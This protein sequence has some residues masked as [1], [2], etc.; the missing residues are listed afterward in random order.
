MPIGRGEAPANARQ[1]LRRCTLWLG[2]RIVYRHHVTRVGTPGL[3]KFIAKRARRFAHRLLPKPR[4]TICGGTR[5]VRGPNRR[6]SE[7][8]QKPCCKACRSLERHRAF[9][10]ILLRL[11]P[12]QFAA[13]RCLQFSKDPTADPA[14]FKSH[15]ISIFG[16]KN[17]LDL[18]RIAR[19]DASYDVIICNHVLE[20]V[21]DYRAALKELR[22][23]L[24]P[25]GFLLLSFPDPHRV[26]RTKD[27]GYADA[28][29]HGHYRI[30]GRD[31]E[32][33]LEVAMTDCR[34][35]RVVE[36][37]DVTG[38]ADMAYVIS[39]NPA[40]HARLGTR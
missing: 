1:L 30:F 25:R 7:S 8:G 28:S 10:K 9:R 29:Q 12:A 38:L 17:S 16:K 3:Q 37:D 22:R 40:L 13:W 32:A 23:V 36:R 2:W 19:A 31:V 15:E 4:C 35:A 33:E 11:D 39:A 5:F 27:W 14:W 18:Q 34:I 24:D 6:L 21:P 20:H 26:A